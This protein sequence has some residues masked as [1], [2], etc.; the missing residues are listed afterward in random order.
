MELPDDVLE[1][2]REFAKPRFKYFREYNHTLKRQHRKSWPELRTCLM[3]RPELVIPALLT[4]EKASIDFQ[5]NYAEYNKWFR[6]YLDD[7]CRNEE[8]RLEKLAEHTNYQFRLRSA[9]EDLFYLVHKTS[10]VLRE[11]LT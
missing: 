11:C 3:H 10:I 7:P 5:Q 9:D 8:T 1:M 6:T 2:I 4:Y